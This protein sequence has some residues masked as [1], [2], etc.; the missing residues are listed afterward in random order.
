M[1]LYSYW[2]S[3]CSWRVRIALNLKGIK[4]EY[5]A[6]HLV[7][8]GGEQLQPEY[9]GMNPMKEVPTLVHNGFVLGQSFAI[10]DYLEDISPEVPLFPKDSK[11]RAKARQLA[12]IVNSGIQPI[13]NLR[14]LLM[15]KAKLG[16]KEKV[17]WGNYWIG[18]GFQ[19][20]EKIVSETA[21][22]Y[23]V[24]DTVTVADVFLIPQIYNARRFK[25]DL[26]PFPTI[27]RIE[28]ELEKIEAFQNAHPDKMPDAQKPKQ[29]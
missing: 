29:T 6:K 8:S 21:G 11:L 1:V 28:K 12:E 2:R 15:V 5:K 10:V 22:K 24:G 23:C 19:A 13:Q 9:A 7:K 3:S 16:D 17:A 14:V 25:V 18:Y 20:F 4:Y 27:L 26:T